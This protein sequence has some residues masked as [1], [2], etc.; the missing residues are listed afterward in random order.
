ML[1]MQRLAA[2]IFPAIQHIPWMVTAAPGQEAH[3]PELFGTSFAN[4]LRTSVSWPGHT[5][6]DARSLGSQFLII[7]ANMELALPC[8]LTDEVK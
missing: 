6:R 8:R 3:T 7:V 1:L 5:I 2:C 4:D